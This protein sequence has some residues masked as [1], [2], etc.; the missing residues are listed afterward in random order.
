[1]QSR[2]DFSLF[3]NGLFIYEYPIDGLF[4]NR[5]GHL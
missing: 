3:I 4:M 5:L 2:Q 1:M